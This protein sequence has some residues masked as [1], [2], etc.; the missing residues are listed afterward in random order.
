LTPVDLAA[1]RPDPDGPAEYAFNSG[2]KAATVLVRGSLDAS[3]VP[4]ELAARP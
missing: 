3:R 1:V 2:E 4:S